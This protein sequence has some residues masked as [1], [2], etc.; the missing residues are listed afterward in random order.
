MKFVLLKVLRDIH[1]TEESQSGIVPST[2]TGRGSTGSSIPTSPYLRLNS[3]VQQM[4]VEDFLQTQMS[5]FGSSQ[6]HIHD[7]NFVDSGTIGKHQKS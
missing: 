1:Q 3:H 7:T 2:R 6:I 4:V 5:N